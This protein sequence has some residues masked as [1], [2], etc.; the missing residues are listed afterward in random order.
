VEAQNIGIAPIGLGRFFVVTIFNGKPRMIDSVPFII[1]N[2]DKKRNPH[3]GKNEIA[4]SALENASIFSNRM[5]PTTCTRF[6]RTLRWP[7]RKIPEAHVLGNF[8]IQFFPSTA[9]SGTLR[10]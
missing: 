2:Q 5:R 7:R 3:F 6:A 9:V 10:G 8:V 4:Q 1:T